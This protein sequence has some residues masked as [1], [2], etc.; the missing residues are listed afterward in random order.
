MKEL[1]DYREHLGEAITWLWDF[2][3]DLIAAMIIGFFGW[4]VIRFINK[5]VR[6]FFERKDYDITLEKFVMDLVNWS[7]KVILFVLI[8][9]QL[10]VESTSLV[11]II[12]AAGLAIGLALQG[13]LANFA[14]GVLILLF[15]PFRVGDF[16]KAQGLEG[17][18][19]EISISDCRL[20]PSEGRLGREEHTAR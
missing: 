19:K 5:M 3:P 4:W 15:K 14:G 13:A 2:L 16:I 17:T 11:A 18:V 9:T 6:K 10:G 7:L 20:S 1:T 12:G 8:I